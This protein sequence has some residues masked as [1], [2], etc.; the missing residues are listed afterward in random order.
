M[1]WNGSGTKSVQAATP[2]ASQ[3]TARQINTQAPNQAN[4]QADRIAQLEAQLA[5]AEDMRLDRLDE[6]E[7]AQED[8][9]YAMHR[10]DVAETEVRRLNHVVA[11]LAYQLKKAQAD[12]EAMRKRLE[13]SEAN[14]KRLTAERAQLL[15]AVA[16]GAK[17][18]AA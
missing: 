17:A 1:F 4:A 12:Q 9:A 16:C 10:A 7:K 5:N 15:I 14:A 3:D 2:Q 6:A 13:A 8:A 18:V 11:E